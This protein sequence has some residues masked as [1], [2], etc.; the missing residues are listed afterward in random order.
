MLHATFTQGNWGDSQ[1]LMVGGQIVN[2]TPGP[3]FGHNWCFKCPNGLCEP[4]L[5]IY[6]SIAFQW[7]EEIVKPLG[8]DPCNCSLNIRESTRALTPNMGIHLGV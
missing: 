5:D 6:I 1:L 8:L 2:L 3:S 4:I 7:Y